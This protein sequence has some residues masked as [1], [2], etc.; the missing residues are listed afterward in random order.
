MAKLDLY[1]LFLGQPNGFTFVQDQDL[2]D[3]PG[4]KKKEAEQFLSSFFIK[5][6]DGTQAL[7]L[8]ALLGAKMI[9][10]GETAKDKMWERIS[11]PEA[12][13]GNVLG[14][15]GESST[16]KRGVLG[17]HDAVRLKPF[18]QKVRLNSGLLA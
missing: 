6:E 16:K 14:G 18:Y 2:A 11:E 9:F 17:L 15:D 5:H 13:G 4:P 8:S 10:F 7:A 1:N 3:M 12:R